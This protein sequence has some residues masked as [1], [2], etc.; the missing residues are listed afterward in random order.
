MAE[1]HIYLDSI[2]GLASPTGSKIFAA[3]QVSV[4]NASKYRHINDALIDV[5]IEALKSNGDSLVAH[6]LEGNQELALLVIDDAFF[7]SLS[8]VGSVSANSYDPSLPVL[9]PESGGNDE[10]FVYAEFQPSA[11][12][13]ALILSCQQNI[14][15]SQLA[16][17]NYRPTQIYDVFMRG[18]GNRF[19]QINSRV[20]VPDYIANAAEFRAMYEVDSNNSH[21]GYG[22]I[23]SNASSADCNVYHG[24]TTQAYRS[25]VYRGNYAYRNMLASNLIGCTAPACET[26]YNNS[27]ATA[28]SYDDAINLD[29]E[30]ALAVDYS[31]EYPALAAN[32]NFGNFLQSPVGAH[33]D[34]GSDTSLIRDALSVITDSAGNPFAA[35]DEDIGHNE[36]VPQPAASMADD[37]LTIGNSHTV[38][39]LNW[40]EVPTGITINEQSVSFSSASTSEIT[41]SLPEIGEYVGGGLGQMLP[42]GEDIDIVVEGVA[43]SL[44]VNS[45]FN[46]IGDAA[47]GMR[48]YVYGLTITDFDVDAAGVVT[49]IRDVGNTGTIGSVVYDPDTAQAAGGGWSTESVATFDISAAAP[50]INVQN[51]ISVAENSSF[52]LPVI[53][54]GFDTV[55]P[56]IGGADATQFQLSPVENG[57]ANL[58]FLDA[59]DFEVP[60][61]SDVDNVYNVDI[62]SPDAAGDLVTESVSVTVTNVNEAAQPTIQSISETFAENSPANAPGA[63]IS[64]VVY[65]NATELLIS[66]N[67]LEISGNSIVVGAAALDV[68][69]IT[70]T[71]TARYTESNGESREASASVTI[72]VTAVSNQPPFIDTRSAVVTRRA[73]SADISLSAD[74]AGVIYVLT[75]QGPTPSVSEMLTDASEQVLAQ[76]VN[77]ISVNDLAVGT[78]ETYIIAS[79]GTNHGLV[80]QAAR[81]VV[82]PAQTITTAGAWSWNIKQYFTYPNEFNTTRRNIY[83]HSGQLQEGLSFDSSTGVLSGDIAG[84]FVMNDL[85]FRAEDV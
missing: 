82:L 24:E 20:F 6:M 79:N 28:C 25:V 2:N 29:V 41:F 63:I 72:T 38:T 58:S 21:I 8:I 59:V 81:H 74:S 7:E 19:M 33:I 66:G 77:T 34:A 37:S 30:S 78:S 85:V 16:P 67:D 84:S 61:D 64:A 5:D 3:A 14:A 83:L 49:S 22:T 12:S 71:V 42:W 48:A 70:A 10:A 51:T 11:Q 55:S 54:S 57:R 76:G 32:A 45:V 80:R 15:G 56:Y 35:N 36:I 27:T 31:V 23:H 68:G 4:G 26:P 75:K 43:G 18:T 39:L 47:I 44:P 17:R 62:I 52:N 73:D 65:T 13:K 40:S 9:L 60:A 1:F 69:T 50:S 46:D 53:F